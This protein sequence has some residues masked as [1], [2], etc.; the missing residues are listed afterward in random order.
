MART[1]M[2]HFVFDSLGYWRLILA[3]KRLPVY[4]KYLGAAENLL[5]STG[6]FK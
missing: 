6:Y 3:L 2:P 4:E 5:R 1:G